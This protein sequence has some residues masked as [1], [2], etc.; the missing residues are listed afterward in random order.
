MTKM[1]TSLAARSAEEK[2][3]AARL[4]RDESEWEQLRTGRGYPAI[5]YCE[6]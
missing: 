1:W 5:T 3:A 4:T 2:G 6:I